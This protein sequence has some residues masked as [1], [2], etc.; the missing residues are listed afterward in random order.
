MT[1]TDIRFV[2]EMVILAARG[3]AEVFRRR[4]PKP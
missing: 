4:K 2:I 1:K 3:L